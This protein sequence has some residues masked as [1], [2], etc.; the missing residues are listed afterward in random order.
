[1]AAIQKTTRMPKARKVMKMVNLNGR[2][3][4]DDVEGDENGVGYEPPDGGGDVDPGEVVENGAHVAADAD[5]DHCGSQD[6]FHVLGEAGD[7]PAPRSHSRPGKGIGAAGVRE[8]GGHL[9]DGVAHADV[10]DRDDAGRGKHTAE[11]AGIETEVPAEEIAGDDCADAQRPKRPYAGVPFEPTLFEVIGVF[12]FVR[13]SG[14]FRTF[15]HRAPSAS[16]FAADFCALLDTS[17]AQS[18]S[19]FA[20]DSKRGLSL[21]AV[22]FW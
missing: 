2:F 11:S 9:G 4:A 18:S 16:V 3:D 6:V 22:Y 19:F 12:R 10:H 13:D 17:P 20:A 14:F 7:E 8:G 5:N 15:G 21:F 1:M